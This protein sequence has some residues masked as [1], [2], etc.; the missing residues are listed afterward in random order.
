MVIDKQFR[1][2][3]EEQLRQKGWSRSELARRMGISQPVVAKYLNGHTVPGPDFMERMLKPFGL[4]LRLVV[5][6]SQESSD[7][8][9]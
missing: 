3:V 4:R 2:I 5:E 1:E 8:A 7:P 6:S 9:A